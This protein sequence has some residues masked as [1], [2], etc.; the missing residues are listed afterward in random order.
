MNKAEA[1]KLRSCERDE[2]N[3]AKSIRFKATVVEQQA[4]LGTDAPQK[5]P[6]AGADPGSI[7]QMMMTWAQDSADRIGEW[8]SGTPR[9]WTEVEWASKIFPKLKNWSA[10]KWHE[11]ESAVSGSG[12]YMHHSMETEIIC[13][14]AFER[15]IEIDK[16]GDSIYR[17]RLGNKLRLWG[18][19]VVAR[20]DILWYDRLHE[21][22]PTDPD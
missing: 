15:L 17:F 16:L 14:E 8:R 4:R 1:R 3:A 9:D 2:K 5:E 20:F 12:H 13:N 11:I 7:Y 10:L 18:F 6:R 22:Y 19:R 21:I